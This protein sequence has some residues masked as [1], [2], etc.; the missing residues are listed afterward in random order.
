MIK[1]HWNLPGDLTRDMYE[2][3]QIDFR[4]VLCSTEAE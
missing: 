4:F 2:M 3:D 1:F